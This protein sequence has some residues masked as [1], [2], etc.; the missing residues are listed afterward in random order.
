MTD[1]PKWLDH[2]MMV[3]QIVLTSDLRVVGVDAENVYLKNSDYT[4]VLHLDVDTWVISVRDSD[5]SPVV[6]ML[7][8]K[9]DE[10]GKSSC[11]GFLSAFAPEE[12]F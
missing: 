12:P 6:A 1:L 7:R 5:G 8:F 2:L 4:V 10:I 11:A 9:A 3:Q